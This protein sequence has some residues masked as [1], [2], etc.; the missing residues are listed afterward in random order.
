MCRSPDPQDRDLILFGN[1]V[2]AEPIELK[3]GRQGSLNPIG[4]V[5]FAREKTAGRDRRADETPDRR[6]GE[7][8]D[9]QAYRGGDRPPKAPKGPTPRSAT[10]SLQR[11]EQ[12]NLS[13]RSCP[14]HGGL[15][16]AGLG[17]GDASI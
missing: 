6:Q 13:C 5:P 8:E 7:D 12:R 17:H 1:R 14:G 4:L 16:M 11:Q 2:V 15:L 10:S 3:P 9:T